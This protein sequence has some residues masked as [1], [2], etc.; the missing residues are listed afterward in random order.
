M[1]SN[2]SPCHE[3][4]Y[5][6][7]YI[8]IYCI[9]YI[10]AI[11]CIFGNFQIY[12]AVML[13]IVFAICNG[14]RN[15]NEGR[16]HLT[17]AVD[18]RRLTERPQRRC[19]VTWE[20]AHAARAQARGGSPERE[21]WSQG[22]LRSGWMKPAPG[23]CSVLGLALPLS[24]A[25]HVNVYNS[26]LGEISAELGWWGHQGKLPGGGCPGDGIWKLR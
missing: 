23:L 25:V 12:I 16:C 26:R 17:E 11:Y 2:F 6:L 4:F 3:N 19:G 24:S 10:F 14:W 13:P 18:W 1:V 8:C 20:R 15:L 7:L 21:G 5:H 22:L 9:L